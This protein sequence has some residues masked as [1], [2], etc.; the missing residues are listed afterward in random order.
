[1]TSKSLL[2][3]LISDN[4]GRVYRPGQSLAIY[5][6]HVIFKG[7]SIISTDGHPHIPYLSGHGGYTT[8]V[9]I[10][11]IIVINSPRHRTFAYKPVLVMLCPGYAV[12]GSSHV[13][14]VLPGVSSRNG[15]IGI[16][17]V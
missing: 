15:L 3:L 16:Y 5:Y 17:H 10:D 4:R 11:G 1:M 6:H 13:N 2:I 8:I 9:N 7:K 12:L 14:F